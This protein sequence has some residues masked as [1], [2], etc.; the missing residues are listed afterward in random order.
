MDRD[1]SAGFLAE[2]MAATS[3]PAWLVEIYFDSGT[4]RMTDA[5]RTI[6]WSGNSYTANGHFLSFSGLEETADMRI[7][8]ITLAVSGVDDAWVALA[9]AEDYMD[10]RVVIRKAFLDYTSGVVSAPSLVFDGR[11]DSLV[12]QDDP[13]SGSTVVSASCVNQWADFDRKAGRHTNDVEQQ[14]AFAGDRF[15]SLNTDYNKQLKWGIA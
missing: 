11:L 8:A 5:W 7:P 1:F 2:I 13:A 6:A 12:I 4:I 3:A 15:F 14:A 10:R 9:L